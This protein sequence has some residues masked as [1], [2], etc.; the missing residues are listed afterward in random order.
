[1]EH[2]DQALA[3][4][5]PERP[6]V[7][8]LRFGTNP[9]V[10]LLTV[11]SLLLWM[12]GYPDAAQQRGAES[13]RMAQ[14]LNHPYTRAYALFHNG[15]LNLWLRNPDTVLEHAQTVLD[16]ADEHGF[17]IWNA[18]GTCLRGAALVATG[19]TEAGLS[20]VEQGVQEYRG[21]KTP[22]VFWPLLLSLC[23]GAYGAAMRPLDGLALMK[24]AIEFETAGSAR[25][26]VSEV[27]ILQG[28]L[29]LLH[30]PANALEA[31]SYYRQAVEA[32]RAVHASMLELRAAIRLSRLWSDQ[33]KTEEARTL[34]SA[35][36]AN[37]TEGFSTADLREAK[38]LLDELS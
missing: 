29:L 20:L 30:S 33:G 22:P 8:R 3:L 32:A 36:Y 26:M 7:R 5:D 18:I 11:S 24:E 2:L 21:L 31:E 38:A 14:K 6:R 1:L 10:T 13:L 9:G 34:L 25:G 27:L 16:L 15:L 19:S 28:D 12:I 35:A 17:Q 37:M 23:A 4:Y